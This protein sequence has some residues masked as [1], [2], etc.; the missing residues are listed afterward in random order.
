M[1]LARIGLPVPVST[2]TPLPEKLCVP[3]NAIMFG[4]PAPVPPMV[5]PEP[6]T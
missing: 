1:E 3:L 4:S 5:T 2:Q 6:K